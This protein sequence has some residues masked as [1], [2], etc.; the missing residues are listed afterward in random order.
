MVNSGC[1]NDTS[2]VLPVTVNT[3]DASFI[4]SPTTGQAPLEVSLTNTTSNAIVYS[5]SVADTTYAVNT[6]TSIVFDTTG[7]YDVTLYVVSPE[8]CIDSLTQTVYVYGEFVL[9][10]PNIFTP[11]GDHTNDYFSI[12]LAGVTY[13]NI[14]IFNRWGQAMHT[15]TNDKVTDGKLVV[16]DGKAQNGDYASDGEYAFVLTARAFNGAEQ[17]YKG[18]IA[19]IKSAK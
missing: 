3:I 13:L 8:G 16:W 10:I 15:Y 6:D 18:F 2:N 1:G 7:Y 9:T 14:D 12:Q 19:L 5:W 4:M 17:V 11:N